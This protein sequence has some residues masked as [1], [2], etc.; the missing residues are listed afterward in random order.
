MICKH[1]IDLNQPCSLC[2]TSANTDAATARTRSPDV[3]EQVAGRLCDA[4]SGL[5]LTHQSVPAS[6]DAGRSDAGD[7][8]KER[9]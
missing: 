1:G 2:A 6:D 5:L 4:G 7:A 9:K 8:E 3:R